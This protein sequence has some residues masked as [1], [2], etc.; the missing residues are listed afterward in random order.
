MEFK[1]SKEDGSAE[2]IFS[3]AEIETLQKHKKLTFTPEG[4]KDFSTHLV[5]ICA[6]FYLNFQQDV[7]DKGTFGQQVKTKK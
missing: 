4:F 5:G 7:K 1:Q 6:E 3:D 2:I